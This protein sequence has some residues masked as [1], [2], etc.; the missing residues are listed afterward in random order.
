[1]NE[2][3]LSV[4][5]NKNKLKHTQRIFIMDGYIFSKDNIVYIYI[6]IYISV[7]YDIN[8]SIPLAQ[9][10]ASNSM[11]GKSKQDLNK[12]KKTY[13]CSNA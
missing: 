13:Y 10:E 4:Y 7:S 6:Y 1:M 8:L 9:L 5:C 11:K 3:K 2:S 12:N